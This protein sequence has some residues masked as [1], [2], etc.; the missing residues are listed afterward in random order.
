MISTTKLKMTRQR[1]IILEELK[2]TDSHPSADDIYERVRARLPRIS[3]GTVY[4][5]LQLLADR[6]MIQKLD[7]GGRQSRFD[8]TVENHYH[9]R[10]LNCGKVE[11]VAVNPLESIQKDIEGLTDYRIVG[12]RLEF[13][14]YCPRCDGGENRG[15]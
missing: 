14:G 13:I 2:K 8:G 12:H 1:R 5:N 6:D 3:L 15:G 10:C 4:R 9:M 11:D 7:L